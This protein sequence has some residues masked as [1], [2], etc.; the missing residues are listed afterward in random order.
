V[1]GAA[2]LEIMNHVQA[3]LWSESQQVKRDQQDDEQY[4]GNTHENSSDT[5]RRI[6]P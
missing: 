3:S 2:L 6:D 5:L 4:G 1:I